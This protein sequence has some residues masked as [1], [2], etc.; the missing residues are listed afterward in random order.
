[1]SVCQKMQDSNDAHLPMDLQKKS[2]MLLMLGI[3]C[4]ST[5]IGGRFQGI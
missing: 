3:C 2:K 4:V 1:M 5:C